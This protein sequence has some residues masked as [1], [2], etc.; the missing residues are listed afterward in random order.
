MNKGSVDQAPGPYSYLTAI[1]PRFINLALV[2]W[3]RNDIR[4]MNNSTPSNQKVL[5]ILSDQSNLNWRHAELGSYRPNNEAS[6]EQQ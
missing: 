2:G 6:N 3:L 1:V 4:S 5:I